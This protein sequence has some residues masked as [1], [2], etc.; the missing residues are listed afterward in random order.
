MKNL[1]VQHREWFCVGLK[2]IDLNISLPIYNIYIYKDC[3]GFD[4]E[5]EEEEIGMV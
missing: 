1:I 3:V 5:V 2:C 4:E